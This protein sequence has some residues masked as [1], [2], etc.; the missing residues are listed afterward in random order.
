MLDIELGQRLV[1]AD[2]HLVPGHAEVL[3]AEGDL[4]LHRPVDRLR[5]DVL[6]DQADPGG[7]AWDRGPQRIQARDHGTSRDPTS[8]ELRHEAVEEPE[9]GGLAPARAAGHEGQARL[10]RQVDLAQGW[11]CSSRVVVRDAVQLGDRARH[12]RSPVSLGLAGAARANAGRVRA[13]QP[14]TSTG[15]IGGRARVG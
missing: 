3:Q 6:E 10:D 5:L 4:T 11:R 14:A 13:R 15:L 8:M 9:K 1:Q 7:Q 2:E 12:D